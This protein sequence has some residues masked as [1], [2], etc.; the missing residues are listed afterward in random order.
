MAISKGGQRVEDGGSVRGLDVSQGATTVRAQAR[1]ESRWGGRGRVVGDGAEAEGSE[2][3]RATAL[4]VLLE[5]CSF[6]EHL[7]AEKE[8]DGVD[9]L[10]G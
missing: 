3:L 1:A 5:R 6:G 2:L 8:G 9:A 7:V 10:R 4:V